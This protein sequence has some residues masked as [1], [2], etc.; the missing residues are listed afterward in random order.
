M[1]E[2]IEELETDSQL[3]I[4]Q[5]PNLGV[6]HDGEVGIEIVR[7]AE[8]VASLSKSHRAAAARAGTPRQISRH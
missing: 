7:I 1:I 6:L 3:G 4:F 5:T 2:E 8:A